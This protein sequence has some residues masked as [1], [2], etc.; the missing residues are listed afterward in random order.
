MHESMLRGTAAWRYTA[1]PFAK[2]DWSFPLKTL[3]MVLP[4]LRAL[5]EAGTG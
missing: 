4:R 3:K 2:G 1:L 5:G